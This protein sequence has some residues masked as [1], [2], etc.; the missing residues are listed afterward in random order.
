MNKN[1]GG[2]QIKL[3]MGESYFKNMVNREKKVKSPHVNIE[4]NED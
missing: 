1:A 3:L 4:C 2:E